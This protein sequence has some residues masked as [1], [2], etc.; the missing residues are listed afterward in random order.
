MLERYTT[1]VGV[2]YTSSLS[3]HS[4]SKSRTPTVFKVPSCQ[5]TKPPAYA[6]PRCKRKSPLTRSC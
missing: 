1:W 4:V 3:A 2:G 6:K 5:E